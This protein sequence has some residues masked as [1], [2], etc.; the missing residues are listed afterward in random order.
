MMSRYWVHRLSAA[1]AAVIYLVRR[2]RKQS[3]PEPST[4][5]DIPLWGRE[6]RRP[7]FELKLDDPEED[8][9]PAVL[10]PPEWKPPPKATSP[11]TARG[12]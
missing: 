5:V 4:T 11:V 8:T 6:P 3:E 9:T 2:V 7:P 1:I 10:S 12:R